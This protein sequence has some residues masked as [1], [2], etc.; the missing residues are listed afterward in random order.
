M[1]IHGGE[2]TT[3][4]CCDRMERDQVQSCARHPDRSIAQT[5]SYSGPPPPAISGSS[6]TTA[7][8]YVVIN[9]CPWCGSDL[10]AFG[11]RGGEIDGEKR[12]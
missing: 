3:G 5:G 12:G 7:D 9:F 4:Y 1:G 10:R 11:H 8:R 2:V 6:S